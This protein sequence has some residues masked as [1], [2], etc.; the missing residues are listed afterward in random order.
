[1]R[2]K[3]FSDKIYLFTFTKPDEC[4]Q[5]ISM[6][7]R[8]DENIWFN[9]NTATNDNE[10]REL[11]DFIAFKTF[12]D[13]VAG[14]RDSVITIFQRYN[15]LLYE[16]DCSCIN[17]G[18]MKNSIVFNEIDCI[19]EYLKQRFFKDRDLKLINV[20]YGKE[21][22]SVNIEQD[23]LFAINNKELYSNRYIKNEKVNN[24]VFLTLTKETTYRIEVS[25]VVND[26][27]PKNEVCFNISVKDSSFRFFLC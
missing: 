6:H 24:E 15:E 5:K 4:L 14:D 12:C 17:F 9:K 26:T 7:M 13:K 20:R 2:S 25:Q 11:I 18:K 8:N 27:I 22:S 23:L 3:M 21:L 19:Y 16:D 10:Y 1:M